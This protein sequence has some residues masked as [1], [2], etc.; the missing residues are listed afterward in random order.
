MDEIRSPR[1]G[2]TAA[3]GIGTIALVA[4]LAPAATGA[5]DPRPG[6]PPVTDSGALPPEATPAEVYRAAC[7]NCHGAGGVG[8]ARSVVAFEEPLPDF[9]DC[10]FATREPDADWF[11]V[12]HAGGPARA[13][14]RM[15]PA[16]G[17]A[18]SDREIQLALDHVRSFCPDR[19]WPR[20]E[21]N[22]PRPL[23]TE[24]AF[25]EDEAVFETAI[26]AEGEGAVESRVVYERRFGARNQV[27]LVVPFSWMEQPAPG[28]AARGATEWNGGLGDVAVGVKRAVWHRFRSGSI[29]S[30]AGEVILPTG[31]D[32][33]GFGGGRVTLEPFLAYG[34]ILPADSFLQ[35]QGGAE[36]PLDGADDDEAF[37]RA[38]LGRSFTA[39]RFGRV[40]TPMLEVL[41]SR[42]LVS[43]ADTHWDLLPELQV[44]LSARQHLM[45]AGGVRIP[46]DDTEARDTTIQ[47]YVL[48]DW[49][50]GGLLE[51]WRHL[52]KGE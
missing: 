31:D 25:P 22:L 46:M 42:E 44:T 43:D 10:S 47:L 12:T 5:P 41:A 35:V 14:S 19:D 49:F 27:E 30:L 34:Q 51:G 17:D 13:F 3:V 16:F 9:T 2:L 4:A 8:E 36:V 24:K 32:D 1:A 28:P 38:A 50:D 20:G 21:L 40:W 6:A 52:P 48:W 15:M 11:A 37:L 7:A 33:E 39:A 23:V 26:D 45:L 29:V 18:L